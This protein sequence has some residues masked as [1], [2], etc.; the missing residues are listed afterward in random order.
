LVRDGRILLAAILVADSQSVA[1]A[2][3]ATT[4][5]PST[6]SLGGESSIE[7]GDSSDSNASKALDALAR[8]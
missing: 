7:R 8:R 3:T 5:K 2:R 1:T 6:R 4:R